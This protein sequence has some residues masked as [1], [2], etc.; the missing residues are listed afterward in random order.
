[1]RRA[2]SRRPRDGTLAAPSAARADRRPLRPGLAIPGVGVWPAPAL[3]RATGLDGARRLSPGQLDDGVVLRDDAARAARPEGLGHAERTGAGD[4]RVDRGLVQPAPAPHL[5]RWA[6]PRGVRKESSGH[7]VCGMI[8]RS[9]LSG[10]PGQAHHIQQDPSERVVYT[11]ED[12]DKGQRTLVE[13]YDK[14]YANPFQREFNR[15]SAKLEVGRKDYP[16]LQ[17]AGIV[18]FEGWQQW[19]EPLAARR[20]LRVGRSR[21]SAIRSLVS[22]PRSARSL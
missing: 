4:L 14:M 6:Q 12:G 3:G 11:F 1:M 7:F 15:L 18:A 17:A 22:G 20:V 16:P 5:D 9:N 10:K 19:R 21:S 2:R 8:S 13:T